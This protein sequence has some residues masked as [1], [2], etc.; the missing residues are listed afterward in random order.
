MQ[1]S[2]II[3][4]CCQGAGDQLELYVFLFAAFHVFIYADILATNTLTWGYMLTFP[5]TIF[6]LWIKDI[7]EFVEPVIHFSSV[8]SVFPWTC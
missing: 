3:K 6:Q 2:D 4:A 7:I 5:W 8:E 1:S